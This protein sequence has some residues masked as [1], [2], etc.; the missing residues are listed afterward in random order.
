[1]ASFPEGATDIL[2]ADQAKQAAERIGAAR[3]LAVDVEADAMHAFRARLCFVQV[4][5]DTDV[6]LFD[7]LQ[8]DVNAAVLAEAGYSEAD[9][10]ALRQARIVA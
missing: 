8:P 3:E 7:T 2:T 10:A 9:I 6:F 4:G 1:M 5:S